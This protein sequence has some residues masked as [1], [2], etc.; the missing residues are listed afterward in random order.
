MAA[1]LD[2][3]DDGEEDR[4]ALETLEATVAAMTIYDE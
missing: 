2:G 3:E 1:G 4:E